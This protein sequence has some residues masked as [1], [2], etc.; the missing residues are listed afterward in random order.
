MGDMTQSAFFNRELYRDG[1]GL[2]PL[3]L[4][5]PAEL[6][7]DRLEV[8]PDVQTEKHFIF[9]IFAEK[10]NSFLQSL[11]VQKYFAAPDKWQPP[12]DGSVR[13]LAKL[14][15]GAPLAVEKQFGKGRVLAFLTTASPVWNNWAR[16]PG[17]VMFLDLQAYL[18]GREEAEP[19][20]LVGAPLEVSL[21]PAKYLPQ[22]RFVTP[23]E[24]AAPSATIDAALDKNT[25][26]LHAVLAETGASGYYEALLTR[27]NNVA[28]TRR[29]AYN[30]DPAEGNLAALD[31][32]QLAERLSGLNYLF[33]RAD[34]F[35][36]AQ[37]ENAGYNLREAILY[38]LIILLILE[39]LLAY[40][41]SY[42]PAL[43][44]RALAAGGVS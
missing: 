20:R 26:K 32:P 16:N 8:A 25:K 27:A 39:Q 12:D 31:Q 19:S 14:R 7:V 4:K 40:S 2:F 13:V 24:A 41:A 35:Q 3:P 36:T 23:Q 22:V 28:E 43:P 44:K 33:D 18:A 10:R 42:H 9:R 21:D 17:V 1:K 6:L 37:N 29:Y 38:S 5:G 34:A 11:L 30:V 15:N